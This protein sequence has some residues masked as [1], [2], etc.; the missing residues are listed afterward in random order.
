[1]MGGHNVTLKFCILGD[2]DAPSECDQVL[3]SGPLFAP[4]GHGVCFQVLEGFNH[5]V[6][7]VLT[8]SYALEETL[9]SG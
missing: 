5:H 6:I 7:S 4:Q 1:M 3:V 2:I 9:F 8:L